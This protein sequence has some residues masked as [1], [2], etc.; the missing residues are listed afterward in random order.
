ME[1][2]RMMFLLCRMMANT[3][4]LKTVERHTGVCRSLLQQDAPSAARR[5]STKLQKT[6]SFRSR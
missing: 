5:A 2:L 4:S 3:L 1:L 6:L